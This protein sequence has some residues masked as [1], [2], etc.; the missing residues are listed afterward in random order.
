[1]FISDSQSILTSKD[2]LRS[3]VA[4]DS[5]NNVT[6]VATSDKNLYLFEKEKRI[7]KIGL[8]HIP[9]CLKYGETLA[10]GQ[11]DGY[12]YIYK[13]LEKKVICNKFSS[14]QAI[15][16]LVLGTDVIFVTNENKVKYGNLQSNKAS[17]VYQSNL[18]ISAFESDFENCFIG[19]E[20]GTVLKVSVS[21]NPSIHVIKKLPSAAA[22]ILKTP[23]YLVIATD[24]MLYLINDQGLD[25][26][27]SPYSS[28][29]G[30]SCSPNKEIL[31]FATLSNIYFLNFSNFQVSKL[32]CELEGISAICYD[33]SGQAV[34]VGTLDGTCERIELILKS[35][36]YNNQ[37][38]INYHSSSTCT[39]KNIHDN[40]QVTITNTSHIQYVE[41]L[42]DMVIC[43]TTS[44]LVF[45]SI[46]GI[47][48]STI[49]WHR[50]VNDELFMFSSF[51]FI[52]ADAQIFIVKD[53]RILTNIH[54]NN[55]NP[56]YITIHEQYIAYYH[57]DLLVLKEL[58]GKQLFSLELLNVKQILLNQHLY[59]ML[60]TSEI[61]YV[62]H[63]NYSKV[64]LCTGDVAF[65]YK[66]LLV[67]Q[68]LSTI[69]IYK[70]TVLVSTINV[71]GVLTKLENE[72]LFTKFNNTEY[73]YPIQ[74][75]ITDLKL[76]MYQH[77]IFN[78]QNTNTLLEQ[79]LKESD[80]YL[81]SKC[82]FELNDKANGYFYKALH[83][84]PELRKLNDFPMFL[85]QFKDK[86]EKLT[87]AKQY[88][89]YDSIFQLD[90]NPS[91]LNKDHLLVY[92]DLLN[93]DQCHLVAN[94]P[95]HFYKLIKKHNITNKSIVLQCA[96]QLEQ[97]LLIVEACELY[98]IL[99]NQDLAINLFIKHNY[100]KYAIPLIKDS[101]KLLDV[102]MRYLNQLMSQ[103]N[104][105]DALELAKIVNDH[106][107]EYECCLY[108]NKVST[109]STPQ[110]K[111]KYAQYL[112]S[113]GL[114]ERSAG[115]YATCDIYKSI[116]I[117][118][119][120]NQFSKAIS[121]NNQ[122]NYYQDTLNTLLNLKEYSKFMKLHQ[123]LNTTTLGLETLFENKL[124]QVVLQFTTDI[125]TYCKRIINTLDTIEEKEYYYL[126]M[127][128]EKGLMLAYLE[129]K[130]YLK[131]FNKTKKYRNQIC[132]LWRIN[133]TLPMEYN[134]FAMNY[135]L[136]IKDIDHCLEWVHSHPE[137]EKQVYTAAA[138]DLSNKSDN[139]CVEY[140]IK[141][142][143]LD[144]IL[145]FYCS[146]KQ[147]ELALQALQQYKLD[148]KPV[149]LHLIKIKE[150]EYANE[151]SIKCNLLEEMSQLYR[152]ERLLDLDTAYCKKYA[153]HKLNQ[154]PKLKRK[155]EIEMAIENN[156]VEALMSQ[157]KDLKKEELERVLVHCI[158]QQTGY[159]YMKSYENK[160]RDFQSYFEVLLLL[161]NKQIQDKDLV[162]K[163]NM[164]LTR[165]IRLLPVLQTIY[166][167]AK[168]AKVLILFI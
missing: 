20:E 159:S 46:N 69:T 97:A 37:Y 168:S 119:Q 100:F 59:V 140:F 62:N 55:L 123:L 137:L 141:L 17:T 167:A 121:I 125:P 67:C 91:D 90:S 61:Y 65:I 139:R 164:S 111:L 143:N 144:A 33:S 160:F 7:D 163:I 13:L 130:E 58:Q 56:N 162:S 118:C 14:S 82:Y 5:Y 128:D 127:D 84:K 79:S 73:Q 94:Y 70:E 138:I 78:L 166:D 2:D 54:C 124:Y 116:A 41:I 98:I 74:F 38:I 88:L 39:V 89:Q 22:F 122:I 95:F 77:D 12:V 8:K 63:N 50:T 18:S 151:L 47:K 142:K 81:A 109:L 93:S 31:V 135:A 28:I 15:I 23:L 113:E 16:H 85:T 112:Y 75:T 165:Y 26:W 25:I 24:S 3:V 150:Y 155:S 153:P 10:V 99:G 27:Q 1:M 145:L 45:K 129:N 49:E 126:L 80:Y 92:C 19:Q 114:L 105:S 60:D 154:S 42:K 44:S 4:I 136:H 120:L 161:E 104:Y 108:L 76:A 103:R 158:Q 35:E 57:D 30:I 86:N 51:I 96:E 48:S 152:Q 148:I 110:L 68:S 132:Y 32:P 102:Q 6:C 156:T 107:K 117:Y 131:A 40:N 71:N 64:L 134:L 29:V 157:K 106:S 101:N 147:T 52:L 83:E 146:T 115:I 34:I 53:N 11:L 9:T 87:V 66:D 72:I 43:K 36:M 149:L 21:E 133:G